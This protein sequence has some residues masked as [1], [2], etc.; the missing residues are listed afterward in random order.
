MVAGL[1]GHSL[2]TAAGDKGRFD[3]AIAAVPHQLFR[4]WHRWS[5]REQRSNNGLLYLQESVNANW[6]W[7]PSIH[8][9]SAVVATPTFELQY[10]LMAQFGAELGRGLTTAPPMEWL[11]VEQEPIQIK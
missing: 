1:K 6:G 4:P 3:P 11:R 8:L 5:L 9:P 2:S 7:K 10:L